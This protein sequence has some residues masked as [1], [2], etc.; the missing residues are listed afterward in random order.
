MKVTVENAG[1]CRRVLNIE[2]PAER[3]NSEYEQMVD[4]FAAQ[5]KIPGF[6]PGKAPRAVVEKRFAKD[7]LQEVK[8]RL[9]PM[10]YHEALQQENLKPV[11]I[12]GVEDVTVLAGQ[13]LSFK[14]TL[15]V[16][17][18]F[19]LPEYKGLAVAPVKVEVADDEVKGTLNR[20]LEQ[21]AK[22]EEVSSRPVQR[23]DLVKL[24]YEGFCDGKAIEEM[25]AGSPGLGKGTDFSVLADENAFLPGFGEGLV[26]AAI[27]EKRQVLVDF[28][29]DFTEK[30]VAGK[31]CTYFAD[32]KGIREKHLPA[33]DESMLKSFGVESEEAL[34][35]RIRED[36]RKMKE[37][38]EKRRQK[39][40][41]IKQ[42]LEK[43]SLDVPESIVAE[44]TKETVYE[45]VRQHIYHGMP[46]AEIEAK[47]GELFEDATRSATEKVKLRYILHRIAE[48]EKVEVAEPEVAERLALMAQRYGM[49]VADFRAEMEKR[50]ALESV[51]EDIRANK[52]LDYVLENATVKA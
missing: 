1:P 30:A 51:E 44:E 45:M 46:Q 21:N 11:A 6:R 35:T 33:L 17:P 7:I 23:G 4:A 16:P 31:K 26:G 19:K 48:Q 49:P 27:G 34:M 5:A 25:A 43:T 12:L 32:V 52:T 38:F 24:D 40:E 8:D 42:L 20:L 10:G 28:P 22:W 14:V 15:D 3:V 47:K 29:A 37:D 18:E 39:S 36:M 13:P 41:I 50:N 9:V 2:I